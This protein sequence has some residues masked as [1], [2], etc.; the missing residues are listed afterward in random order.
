MPFQEDYFVY[1][2]DQPDVDFPNKKPTE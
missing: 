2:Y 1:L